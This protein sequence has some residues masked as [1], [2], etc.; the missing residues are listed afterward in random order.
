[1]VALD[2]VRV[3]GAEGERAVSA[4]PPWMS[5]AARTLGRDACG[6]LWASLTQQPARVF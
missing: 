3:E 1:M 4:R 5:V 2:G 6:E